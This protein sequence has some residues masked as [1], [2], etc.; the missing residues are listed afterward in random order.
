MTN[1]ELAATYWLETCT[2]L[3]AE[4]ELLKKTVARLE[5]SRDTWKALSEAWQWL[6]ENKS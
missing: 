1:D 3:R 2:A 5:D 4:I 6:A